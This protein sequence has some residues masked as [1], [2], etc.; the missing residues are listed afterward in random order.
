[1]TPTV[2]AVIPTIGRPSLGRAV[3][4][5]L[6]QTRPVAEIIVVADTDGPVSVPPDDRIMVLR[7]GVRSG[8]ARCRQLG[9][10]AASGSV[11]ALLDD[12][13]VWSTTKL[14]RQLEVVDTVPSAEWIASSRMLVLGPGIRQRTWPRRLVKPG[15][16]LA[17]YL[18]RFSRLRYGDTALPTS[19]LCFPAELAREVR[20]DAHAGAAHDEPSWLIRVQ[21]TIPDVRVVQLPDALTSYNIQGWSV[22]RDRS[23]RV[24]EYID[25]GL[26][27]LATESPRVLGDYLC[28]SPVSAAVSACS[29]SG[30]QR[31][32][33]SALR[34]GRPG[35]CALAYATLNAAR[36]VVRSARTARL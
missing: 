18:F 3:L 23:D 22:S 9:V 7:A 30:V 21:R 12:D 28:T 15:E 10:D 31:S 8:P 11:I 14:A 17:E 1:M 2:S 36:I 13:D 26:Q 4:S 27:Y 29:L 34:Y 33:Q 6:K 5:V 16:S 19:T 24:D 20:W 25:W 32:L 35:P